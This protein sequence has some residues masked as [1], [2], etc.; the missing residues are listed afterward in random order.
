MI[1]T[2][3]FL[4]DVELDSASKGAVDSPAQW[5]SVVLDNEK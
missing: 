1:E 2:C 3:F 4:K 5:A